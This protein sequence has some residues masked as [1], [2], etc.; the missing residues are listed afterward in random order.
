MLLSY[1]LEMEGGLMTFE[2]SIAPT[3]HSISITLMHG[4]G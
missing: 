3:V 4:E 1:D 2:K